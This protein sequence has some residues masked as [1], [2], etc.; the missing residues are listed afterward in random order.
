MEARSHPPDSGDNNADRVVTPIGVFGGS[1]NTND[2]NAESAEAQRENADEIANPVSSAGF[3]KPEKRVNLA[4]TFN[5]IASHLK[6][7]EQLSSEGW[8]GWRYSKDGDVYRKPPLDPKSDPRR[9]RR[10]STKKPEDHGTLERSAAFAQQIGPGGGWGKV[11]KPGEIFFDFD[12]CYNPETQEFSPFA[13]KV[14]ASGVYCEFSPGGTGI[15]AITSIALGTINKNISEAD[16]GVEIFAASLYA[17]LTAKHIEGTPTTLNDGAGLLALSLEHI[18]EYKAAKLAAEPDKGAETLEA[19]DKDTDDRA[20]ESKVLSPFGRLNNALMSSIPEWWFDVFEHGYWS[21]E[22]LRAPHDVV[23]WARP[24]V[25]TRLEEGISATLPGGSASPGI[26]DHGM[27]GVNAKRLDG[28]PDEGGRRPL[29]L[30]AEYVVEGS[31]FENQ[32]S[33][34]MAA[35][36]AACAAIGAKPEHFGFNE[37]R[38]DRSP[39]FDRADD[40]ADEDEEA[41]EF[42]PV[43]RSRDIL[44]L[45]RPRFLIEGWFQAGSENIISGP[46]GSF[47]SFLIEDAVAS[48]GFALPTWQ[49]CE[50]DCPPGLAAVYIGSE[51]ESG[52]RLR[53]AAWRKAR[54]IADDDEGNYAFIPRSP[55]FLDPKQIDKLIAS[56]RRAFPQGV[57]LMAVDTLSRSI[58]GADENSSKDASLFNQAVR[59]LRKAFNCTIVLVHHVAK[60]SGESRGHGGFTGDPQGDFRVKPGQALHTVVHCRKQRNGKAH[61]DK[62]FRMDEVEIEIEGHHDTS[63]VPTLVPQAE[64]VMRTDKAAQGKPPNRLTP[65]EQAVFAIF[66]GLLGASADCKVLEGDLKAAFVAAKPGAKQASLNR[67][68]REIVKNLDKKGVLTF[69]TRG[70]QTAFQRPDGAGGA[71]DS[72]NGEG[73]A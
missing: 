56:I 68:F 13:K 67:R 57:A 19:G 46:P 2:N 71:S 73:Q 11:P 29:D 26:T 63:L 38:D 61:W 50:I 7:F 24:G 44:R 43:L 30:F 3:V 6:V 54:G 55:N 69:T 32:K 58:A 1:L 18:E 17:T 14:L 10:A 9:P 31:T 20:A 49:G 4:Y 25:P 52:A 39:H 48:V 70:V 66:L 41:E 27:K 72:P 21:G 22:T 28:K 40:I 59:R 42:Y 51:P 8:L 64:R 15:R 37:G 35:V 47:K 23:R 65:D 45:P 33:K 16:A 12:N 34:A 53:H 36:R 62:T 5:G 60:G